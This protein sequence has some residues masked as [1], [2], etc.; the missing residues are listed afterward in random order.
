MKT[1]L[2]TGLFIA[3]VILGCNSSEK[4]SPERKVEKEKEVAIVHELDVLHERINFKN[5]DLSLTQFIARN[6]L[7]V[8]P[9]KRIIYLLPFG[10]M[11]PEVME[12]L[13]EELVYFEAFFQLPV[14]ILRPIGFDT[15]KNVNAVKTRM[16]PADDYAYYAKEKGESINLREQIEANTFM[17]VFMQKTKPQDAY[18]VLGITEHDIYNPKYNYLFGVSKLEGGIGLV[19]TYRLIDYKERTKYNLRRVITKQIVNMFGIKNVKDYKCLMNFHN[20]KEALEQGEFKLSPIAMEKLQYCVDFD[21]IKRFH[22]LRKIWHQE[23]HALME[24]HYTKAIT[25]LEK[26]RNEKTH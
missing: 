16:V 4:K 13:K 22:D 3:T 26:K 1:S 9:G 18:A 20:S 11:K 17:E 6:P 5:H 14:K 19:S 25:V 2:C 15:I 21:P 10:N 7:K 24:S 12:I 23:Q 8:T